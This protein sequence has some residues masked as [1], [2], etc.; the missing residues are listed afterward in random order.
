MWKLRKFALTHSVEKYN[1]MLSKFLRENQQFF[2]QITS[3]KQKKS[4]KLQELISRKIF[5]R[6]RVS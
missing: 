6:D 2:R 3:F 4:K 1:K 5:D